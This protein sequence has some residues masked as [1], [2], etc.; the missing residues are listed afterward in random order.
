MKPDMSGRIWRIL[1]VKMQPKFVQ[2]NKQR[3][4]DPCNNRAGA[5]TSLQ[6]TH[7]C[8][9]KLR[10]EFMKE[11]K[12]TPFRPRKGSKK[13]EKKTTTVKKRKENTLSIKKATK[14][15]EKTFLV[16]CAF[17]LKFFLSYFL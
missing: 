2:T 14:K 6:L 7:W 13:K 10:W 5:A 16:E 17:F 3:L 4:L 8:D 1:V 9:N 11:N 12:K 15:E